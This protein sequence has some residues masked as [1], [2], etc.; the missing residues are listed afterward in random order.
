MYD[1]ESVWADIKRSSAI[2]HA[3][4][5]R[6]LFLIRSREILVVFPNIAKK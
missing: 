6:D 1:N 3:Q 5:D 4:N 2:V